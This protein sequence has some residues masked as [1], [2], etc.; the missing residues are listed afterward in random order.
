MI[1]VIVVMALIMAWLL[2]VL[3]SVNYRVCV[4]EEVVRTLCK[5]IGV[6]MPEVLD[7]DDWETLPE[8]STG[9][10]ITYKGEELEIG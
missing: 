10:K 2:Y 5:R 8:K 7:E 4:L 1:Y 9:D 6:V 3:M